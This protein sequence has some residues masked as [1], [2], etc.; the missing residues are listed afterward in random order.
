MGKYCLAAFCVWLALFLF[1]VWFPC[2]LSGRIS[3]EEGEVER[4]EKEG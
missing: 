2:A 1:L 3:D 4:E